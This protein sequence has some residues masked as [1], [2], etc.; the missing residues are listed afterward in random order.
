M[1][2]GEEKI[3][4]NR[5]VKTEEE[6]QS[7]VESHETVVE[8]RYAPTSFAGA[9][10]ASKLR[11]PEVSEVIHEPITQ[12]PTVPVEALS[13]LAPV[14]EE[15]PAVVASEGE[16]VPEVVESIVEPE[17]TPVP[18]EAESDIAAELTRAAKPVPTPEVVAAAAQPAQAAQPEAQ[19]GARILG[20][21]DL[22]Q[23][24]RIEP[25]PTPVLRRPPAG[26]PGARPS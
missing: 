24:M 2:V 1:H 21:I 13:A 23:T 8:R 26:A 11:R 22:K 4:A 12:E 19:R 25:A 3:V 16:P 18:A 9:L 5:V 17:P 20:R 6:G 10:A 7:G 15:M 14:E